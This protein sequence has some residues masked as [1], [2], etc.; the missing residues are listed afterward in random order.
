MWVLLA[1]AASAQLADVHRG[2]VDALLGSGCRNGLTAAACSVCVALHHLD[3]RAAGCTSADLIEFCED[4][5]RSCS[6]TMLRDSSLNLTEVAWSGPEQRG[7]YIGAPSLVTLPGGGV[8]VS[9]NRFGS[10]VNFSAPD[11]GATILRSSGASAS[12]WREVANVSGA[13]DNTLFVLKKTVYLLGPACHLD[14]VQ[15]ARSVDGARWPTADRRI[16][17]QATTGMSYASA[18]T[19]VVVANGRVYRAVEVVTKA[20]NTAWGSSLILFA[21]VPQDE[22]GRGLLDQP[23][24]ASKPLAFG[25]RWPQA[26]WPPVRWGGEWGAKGWLEGG[27]VPGPVDATNQSR[28]T[29]IYVV[30][31]L[32]LLSTS[33]APSHGV[34]VRFSHTDNALTFDRILDFPGGHSKFAIRFDSATG[35][36]ISLVNNVTAPPE[37]WMTSETARLARTP[38]S[39]SVSKDL[40]RWTTVS[41]ILWDDTGFA[42]ADSWK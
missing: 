26:A 37:Q 29:S 11:T 16:V 34:L 1:V 42:E 13:C 15:L 25:A 12:V 27:V 38:L 31:R 20:D 14:A 17:L 10:G 4:S 7:I 8:L 19:T 24:T 39:L 30:L 41:A 21:A 5:A 2:C 22:D 18:P 23:W 6:G 40:I 3:A 35:L 28:L 33:V 36:Y 32:D 9:S